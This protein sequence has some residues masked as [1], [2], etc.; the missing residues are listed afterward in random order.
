MDKALEAWFIQEILPY[1]AA[2]TRY[3][4]QKRSRA[5]DV[6]DLRND[7]YIRVLESASAVRPTVPRAFLFATARN[8][9]IDR[10]RHDRV[11]KIDQLE[12]LAVTNVLVDDISTEQQASGRQQLQRLAHLFDRLPR[13]CR[14]VLWMR[15]IEGLPQKAV[16]V[17]LG[18]AEATVEK[19]LYRAVK[20]LSEALNGNAIRTD[21][22][23]HEHES[24]IEPQHGK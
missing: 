3:L 5:H 17:R 12:G 4:A 10:T 7:I 19:H 18:L 2:L 6:E 21:R 11:V 13:R 14:E 8:L 22:V 20:T 24:D 16:A 1:E 9:L 23:N 15:K